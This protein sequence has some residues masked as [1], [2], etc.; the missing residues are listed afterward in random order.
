MAVENTAVS[1]GSILAHAH[2]CD[3]IQLLLKLLPGSSKGSLYNS[4]LCICLA[5]YF[6][7][8]IRHTEEHHLVYPILHYFFQFFR[9]TVQTVAELS[10][11]SGNLFFLVFP[12]FYKKRID[13]RAFIHSGLSDHFPDGLSSSESSGSDG[14]IHFVNS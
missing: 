10:R 7:F 4:I 9:H 1:M 11:H 14:H 13:E 6:I 2:V 8:L 5:S 3:Q 12:L